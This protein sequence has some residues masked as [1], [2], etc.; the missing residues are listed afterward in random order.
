MSAPALDRVARERSKA[1]LTSASRSSRA[2]QRGS[3]S[4][5]PL[6][7]NVGSAASGSPL[8]TASYAAQQPTELA[9]GPTESSVNESGNAP[10]RGT[11]RAVGFQP[12][13]PQSAAGPR[14]EPRVSEPSDITA[15]PSACATAAPDDD[16]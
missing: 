8:R 9:S 3:R 13:T 10:S 15:M 11:R 2:P 16:P 6:A 1:R 4:R 12:V 5:R 7:S 14:I